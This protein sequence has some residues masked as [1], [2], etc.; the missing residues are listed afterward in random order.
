M[1]RNRGLGEDRSSL[2]ALAAFRYRL[3]AF[4]QCSE[5]AAHAAGLQHQQYQLLLQVAGAPEG[6]RAT[7]A[8]A[9][10]RL[11]LRHNSTVELV[12]RSV[13]ENLVV[14]SEDATDRRRVV[15][16]ITPHGETVLRGLADF[17]VRQLHDLV[18]ELLRVI[19]GVESA[20][21]PPP[22]ESRERHT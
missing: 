6:A 5:Q 14:R 1:L 12:N 11:G 19:G 16:R 4:L 9:A 10:E 22:G 3:R 8:Y 7:I 20:E 15:L 21:P 17:H 13:S 18:P 2:Q